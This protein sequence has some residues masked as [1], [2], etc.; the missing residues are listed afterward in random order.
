MLPVKASTYKERTMINYDRRGTK[1][2]GAAFGRIHRI[3]QTEVCHLW[4]LVSA[5]TREGM[6]FQRLSKSW[7]KN[8]A[9]WA[10]RCLIF[11]AR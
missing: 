8:G 7:K 6:V 11:W 9:H 10:A 3:G 1:P 4:N 5:Q 2:F